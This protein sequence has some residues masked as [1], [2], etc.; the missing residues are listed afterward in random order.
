MNVRSQT[1]SIMDLIGLELCDL[2]ALELKNAIF[3][4]VYTLASANKDQS[5]QNLVK[6]YDYK[7]SN[8]F[9]YG[10]NQT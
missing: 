1:F 3:D 7:I 10:L 9:D 5:S 6:I 4:F 8:D 2:S